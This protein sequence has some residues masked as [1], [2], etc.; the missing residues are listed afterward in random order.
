ML[1]LCDVKVQGSTFTPLSKLPSLTQL[2]LEH[3]YAPAGK[4]YALASLKGLTNLTSLT[5][6][7]GLETKTE[8]PDQFKR[9]L[10]TADVLACIETLHGLRCLHLDLLYTQPNDDRVADQVAAHI[11]QLQHLTELRLHGASLP[12]SFCAPELS[13]ASCLESIVLDMD[14][15]VG[16]PLV[17]RLV[18]M[19]RLQNVAVG[20]MQ[21]VKD[22]SHLADRCAW[23]CLISK[24]R[25]PH[26][27]P[28]YGTSLDFTHLAWLPLQTLTFI[29]LPDI[30]WTL[31]TSEGFPEVCAGLRRACALV[32]RLPLA[33]RDREFGVI[34]D[35]SDKMKQPC[36][37]AFASLAALNNSSVV[38]WLGAHWRFSAECAAAGAQALDKLYWLNIDL[39]CPGVDAFLTALGDLD[40]IGLLELGAGNSDVPPTDEMREV[41]RQMALKRAR[42]GYSLEILHY[43]WGSDADYRRFNAE[44]RQHY[45]PDSDCC[46]RLVMH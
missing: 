16:A 27:N 10:A 12:S 20:P 17:E 1:Y 25:T 15:K 22:L 31:P 24:G 18:R 6:T 41:I 29:D 33:S 3:V 43:S 35:W 2:R 19:P 40:W 36:P 42:A 32:A 26:G 39:R 46:V 34:I 13:F 28:E 9:P 44:V 30:H 37:E 14:W 4:Q 21:V 11:G 8:A 7:H 23:Q 45:A 5:V 38:M